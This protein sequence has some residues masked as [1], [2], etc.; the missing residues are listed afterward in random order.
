MLSNEHTGIWQYEGLILFSA[1]I[2]PENPLESK[3]F[4][5]QRGGAEALSPIPV[6][7][8]VNDLTN[9]TF[10]DLTNLRELT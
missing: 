8:S 4:T 1:P 9:Q 7:D 5:V 10:R 6:Y 3:T 2:G